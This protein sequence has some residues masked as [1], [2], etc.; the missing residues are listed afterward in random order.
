MINWEHIYEILLAV[1]DGDKKKAQATLAYL[2]EI[3]KK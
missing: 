1:A 3:Y 2:K